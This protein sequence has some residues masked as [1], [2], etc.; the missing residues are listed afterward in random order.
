MRPIQQKSTRRLHKN[1]AAALPGAVCVQYV[2]GRDGVKRGP[3]YARMWRERGRLRKAY[4]RPRDLARVRAACAVW[5]QKRYDE[6]Q[7][8]REAERY[9]HMS[10]REL[11]AEIE[12]VEQWLKEHS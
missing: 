4:V 12:K 3:Y 9:S 10:A 5:H 1:T 11:I 8:Q 2:K 7:Q 6:R